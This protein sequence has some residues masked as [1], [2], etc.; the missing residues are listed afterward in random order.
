MRAINISEGTTDD[1][2]PT[3]TT[4]VGDR[5]YVSGR[6]ARKRGGKNLLFVTDEQARSYEIIMRRQG[7]EG[8]EMTYYNHL[9]GYLAVQFNHIFIGI[10][11]DGY[12]HS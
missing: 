11:P 12:A 1:H 6:S 4:K 9:D 8:Y 2:M 7:T 3:S 10:E 5:V